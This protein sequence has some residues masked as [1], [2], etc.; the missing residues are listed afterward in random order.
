MVFWVNGEIACAPPA[1]HMLIAILNQI[2]AKEM[3]IHA[4][5]CR[6]S[7]ELKQPAELPD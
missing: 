2:A 6:G 3:R 7:S 5:H 1:T 4:E